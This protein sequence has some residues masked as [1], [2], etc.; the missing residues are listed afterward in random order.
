M[1]M[2]YRRI[3]DWFP[4]IVWAGVEAIRRGS[5]LAL[6]VLAMVAGTY[7]TLAVAALQ[8]PR[9][10]YLYYFLPTVPAIAIGLGG[11]LSSARIPRWLTFA[12]LAAAA[13][14]R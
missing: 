14:A 13:G 10:S 11:I 7:L 9:P 3:N 4:V 12:Y 5:Q 8:T 2:Q 6:L 1:N